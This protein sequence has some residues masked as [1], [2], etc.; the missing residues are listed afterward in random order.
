M[1]GQMLLLDGRQLSLTRMVQDRFCYLVPREE[2]LLLL[3]STVEPEA[4]FAESITD[5]GRRRMVEA[6]A[7]LIPEV[8]SLPIL[9]QWAG[10]RPECPDNMPKI[11]PHPQWPNLILAT[12]HFRNGILLA[13]VTGQLIAFFRCLAAGYRPDSPSEDSV[14]TRVVSGFEIHR[15]NGAR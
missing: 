5:S 14:I 7:R 11:G 3:G 2:G 4:G 13:P 12:G 15:P 8:A 1:R 9:A 6:G 10:L